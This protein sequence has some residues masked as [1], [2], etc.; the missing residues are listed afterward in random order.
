MP[1]AGTLYVVATPIGNLEDITLRAIKVLKSVQLV[2]AE[3]TRRTGILLR[4]FGIDVAILSVHEHNERARTQKVTA[5]LAKG[6]SVALVTDAGTPGVSDPGSALVAA[7]RAEGFRIEPIPGASAVAT[8]I[9]VAGINSDGFTFLGFAPVRGK[10][11]KK[12][13]DSLVAASN[14]RAAVFFEAPHRLLKTIDELSLLV[15]RPI[16]VGRELTKLHEELVWGTPKE[17]LQKFDNPHGEFTLII[18]PRDRAAE[19][20]DPPDDT[21]IAALVGQITE[22]EQPK[23]LREAARL[24]GERLG[25]SARDVYAALERVK[26][27]Q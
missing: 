8:A 22:Q 10:D 4:H 2:A 20:I 11:R 15:D 3:D 6:E 17:L 23:S 21:E 26:I 14:D 27:G 12:W 25:M 7:V 24:A 1:P 9:S 13:F 5:R 16:F 18:P 19:P